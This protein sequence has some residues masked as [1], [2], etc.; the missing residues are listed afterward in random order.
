MPPRSP[1]TTTKCA[2][3]PRPQ[4]AGHQER[5]SHDPGLPVSH[6]VTHFRE[7]RVWTTPSRSVHL[8]DSWTTQPRVLSVPTHLAG[9]TSPLIYASGKILPR[10]RPW[11]Q[12]LGPQPKLNIDMGTPLVRFPW[13]F[14]LGPLLGSAPCPQ[15]LPRLCAMTNP[16]N[17]HP[18]TASP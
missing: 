5:I 15:P 8:L 16:P 10:D 11:S 4:S 9:D 2:D 3:Q 13:G 12:F 7:D 18:A 14:P 6:H 17:S 1:A